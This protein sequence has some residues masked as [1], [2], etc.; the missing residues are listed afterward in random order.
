VPTYTGNNSGNTING[1]NGDDTIDGLGGGDTLSGGNGN[2]TIDGGSGDDEIDGGNGNDDLEGGSGEDLIDGGNGDD[3]IDGGADDDVIYGGNGGDTL[4]GGGGN[5]ELY[6]ENGNDFLTGGAGDDLLDGNNGFD[7]AYYS[8]LIGE[9]SFFSAAGY[10]HVVHLGGAGADG[11]DRLIRVERLVFADRVID[12]G[13]GHN[14]PVALDDHV[15]ITEDSGT[16]S[17]GAASVKDNDFDFDGDALTVTGGT[18]VGTY[19]TLTLNANGTY[20]YTLNASAQAL[21]DGEIVADSFNYTITDNDGSDTGALVFHIAGVNDAPVANDDAAA[22]SED[23]AVAGNVLANDTDVDVEPLTVANPGTYLGAYGTLALAAD[24]SYTYTPNAAAQAL[25]DGEVVSDAFGYVASDGT[26]SDTATLTVTVTG[27]NDAPVANDD[28]AATG[29]DAAV[30]GNVLT[31]DTDVDVEPLT[32]TTPGTYVGTYGTLVLAADGSYTYTPNAAAQG[33]DDGEVVSDAFGYTASD[34]TASDTATLTVDVTGLNDAPVANDDVASTTEDAAVSGNVLINDTD[35]DVEPLTVTTPGSY[36]G[37]YGTL[38]LAADG[39]YTYTPNAA[40][41]ALDDG[42]VVSD[43]FGYTASDGT[44]SD[45]ATL[46]VTVTGLNDAPVANDDSAATGEDAAVSGNVLANDT[47]VD[48]EPLTVTTPGTYAGSYGTLMLAADGSYT[49]TP[50]AAANGLA[51]G[52]VAQDLFGYTASDGTASDTATLTVTVNGTND[53]PTIDAGGTDDA[54]SVTELPNND[55][56]E[57]AFTHTD[58]G[59]IAFD[60]VDVSDSHSASV[61]PQGGGYLG[62]FALDPVNQA[63]DTVG[64]DF[65]VEDSDIDFLDA[66]ETLTQIYTV[67]IDDGNGGT[68]TQDVTI[69]ITGEADAIAP[70]GTNWY[71]DNSAVGSAETGSPSDPFTSIAAFNAAQGTPGGPGVGDNIFLLAGSGTYAEADGINLLDGQV[72]TGVASG[73]LR[74][75]IVTTGGGSDGIELAQN[76]TVSGLDIGNTNDTGITDSNGSVGNLTI[77]D[78]GKTGSGQVIDIDQGGTLDVTLNVATSTASNDGAIDLNGLAGS[79]TVTGATTITGIH[80]DGG[81][82]ITSSSLT[83]TFAGGGTVSTNN[84]VAVNFVGNTGALAL[85]GGFDI[86]TTTGLGLNATGGGTLTATG[87]GNSISSLF[88]TALNVVNTAIGAADATF[89]SIS[90][91]GGVNGIVLTNTGAVGGLTV[92]GDGGSTN[93]GSGGTIQ[94]ST[95]DAIKLTGT[96]GVAL[97]QMSILDSGRSGIDGTDVTDFAFTNGT[98]S[99]SG[100]ASI[101]GTGNIAFNDIASG[102]NNLDGVVTITGSTLTDAYDSG[103]QIYNESGTISNITITDNVL[104][105][106]GST[107]TSKGSGIRID[108][109]GSAASAA[110]VTA[111]TVSGNSI[112]DFVSGAGIQFQGGNAAQAAPVT[113]GVP[114][115]GMGPGDGPGTGAD[116]IVIADNVIGGGSAGTPLGTLGIIAGTSG[117]GQGNFAITGNTVSHFLNVGIAAFGGNKANVNFLVDNNVIDA[118]DN[119]AG[120][121]GISV[122]AQLGGNNATQNGTI[123]AIISDNTVDNMEGNGIFA[124]VTNSFNTGYFKI[125]DNTVGSPVAGVRPGIRVDAG[126]SAGDTAVFLEIANNVSGGSGGSAGIGLRKQGSVAT[127]NDFHID[128]LPVSPATHAQVEAYV[129]GLNP[130]SQVGTG[131]GGGP[132]GVISLSGQNYLAGTVDFL[133]ADAPPPAGHDAGADGVVSQAAL[134]LLTEAAIQHWIDAGATTG[135]VAVL[136]AATVSVGAMGDGDLALSAPGSILLDDDGAGWGWFIDQTPGEDSEFAP[137]GAADGHVDLLTVLTHEF[138]HQLGLGHT[139]DGG[140]MDGQLA[141]GERLLPA[142]VFEA[143]APDGGEAIGAIMMESNMALFYNEVAIV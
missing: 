83:A 131:N 5:D 15:S 77:F 69:T 117:T 27:L 105:A 21:D 107:L 124:G 25:D 130:G 73:P 120:A 50:N 114:G 136:R 142:Q 100:T 67:E 62:T 71:I 122:G 40:A 126:T 51:A 139:A 93:N 121:A 11:H 116:I 12:I 137:G 18:F 52:E 70:D 59:T 68:A 24:G 2:D 39:S 135:Q 101:I 8:G 23:A 133:K 98:I 48:V 10:L 89:E 88:A 96:T 141:Q 17:S 94:N 64:W 138:G 43:A 35:V 66:G 3:D 56:N 60:D 119:L 81:I 129:S 36:A 110:A 30:S 63:G 33:L 28:S 14:K 20:S 112:D 140:V 134:A 34:G 54:G 92:T 104:D 123:R 76:N 95:G 84:A 22:T 46:T 49:Y 103:I 7:I 78:V 80:S 45:T 102:I 127:T 19:G 1:G 132:S 87:A 97:D 82:D 115:A 85:G 26:A 74:P 9:Y 38:A 72:L 41:Q 37:A 143:V 53:A 32:V 4:A 75:T 125:V 58:S 106:S 108:V 16:Y 55:P 6:G 111:A 65:S 47:D 118:T 44:A 91:G 113:M 86:V 13:S 42:E 109:N 128:G 57:N 61:T 31:N 90:S 79:F 99:N 29:E